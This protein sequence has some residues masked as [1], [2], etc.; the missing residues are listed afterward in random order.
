MVDGAEDKWLLPHQFETKS[1]TIAFK[2]RLVKIG[3]D[4]VTTHLLGYKLAP[5]L[6]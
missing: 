5:L 6:I 2:V 3:F 1:G 4:L